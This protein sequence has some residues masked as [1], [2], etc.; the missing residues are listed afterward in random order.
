MSVNKVEFMPQVLEINRNA[1]V[2]AQSCE[3]VETAVA[4][5][6]FA[7]ISWFGIR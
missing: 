5:R 4:W 2:G 6:R 7:L 3:A 1:M